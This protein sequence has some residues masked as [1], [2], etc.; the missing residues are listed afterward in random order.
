MSGTTKNLRAYIPSSEIVVEAQNGHLRTEWRTFFTQLW[1]RTG[2][3]QGTAPGGGGTITGV[4]AGNGLSGGGTTGTVT[5]TL[6]APVSIANGGTFATTATQALTNLGALPLA[7][8]TMAG[9]LT[10]QA[11]P[12]AALQPVT[13]Q[14]YTA[15]LPAPVGPS[16]TLPSMDGTAAIGT[17]TTYARADHVHPTDTSRYAASNPSGYQTAAQVTASLAPYAPLAS[18]TFTGTPTLPT[19]TVAV[20]QAAGNSTTAVATTAFVEA[21]NSIGWG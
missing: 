16:T 3:S 8:G 18:P 1:E 21:M 9:A 13:L 5:L 4:T 20:T 10:L 19:G 15:H 12:A 7:G 11:D 17:G 14:Y 2:G 6:Q